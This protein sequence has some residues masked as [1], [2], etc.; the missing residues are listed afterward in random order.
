MPCQYNE[1][2]IVSVFD[3]GPPIPIP[4]VELVL[5]ETNSP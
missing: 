3:V 4:H 5:T 1:E 2:S